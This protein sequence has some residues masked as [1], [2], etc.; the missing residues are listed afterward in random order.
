MVMSEPPDE[1]GHDYSICQRSEEL[2]SANCVEKNSDSFI[3][4]RRS[5]RTLDGKI[6]QHVDELGVFFAKFRN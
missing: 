4:G 6:T 2:A 5:A 3:S 1:V